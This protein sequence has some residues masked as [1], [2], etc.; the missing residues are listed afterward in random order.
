M[1]REKT[2]PHSNSLSALLNPYGTTQIGK[3]DTESCYKIHV[4]ELLELAEVMMDW[5]AG[6]SFAQIESSSA[7][8]VRLFPPTYKK[9]NKSKPINKTRI[10]SV[11]LGRKRFQ[12]SNKKV[13]FTTTRRIYSTVDYVRSYIVKPI[14]K[15]LTVK[16][17]LQPVLYV[18]LDTG[19]L[20]E[21][22]FQAYI[23]A[24][25]SNGFLAVPY[26]LSSYE[27]CVLVVLGESVSW[28]KAKRI[29]EQLASSSNTV[30][31]K[32]SSLFSSVP[33]PL[34]LNSHDELCSWIDKDLDQSEDIIKQIIGFN[35]AQ[36]SAL[37]DELNV[38]IVPNQTEE[39]N[40]EIAT[41]PILDEQPYFCPNDWIVERSLRLQLIEYLG[42]ED[43]NALKMLGL[44]LFGRKCQIYKDPV[45][46]ESHIAA[47]FNWEKKRRNN[48]AI[49]GPAL[50]F[51][52]K[53]VKVVY[54]PHSY[55]G[56]A[57]SFKLPDLPQSL[58][59]GS[60]KLGPYVDP[61]L[62]GTGGRTREFVTKRIGQKL[63]IAKSSTS[64]YP[65][66]T[67]DL[68][69]EH[70]NNLPN[71]YFQKITNQHME[72]MLSAVRN[73][74]GRGNYVALN[75]LRNIQLFPQPIY[76][77]S[78]KTCRIY[79]VGSS[80]QNLSRSIRNIAFRGN[81]KV[82]LRH[83]QLSIA[84]YLYGYH[85]LDHH[86]KNGTLWDYLVEETGLSKGKLKSILYSSF[87]MSAKE[88]YPSCNPALSLH[89]IEVDD[90]RNFGAVREMKQLLDHRTT[91]IY[92][93]LDFVQEDV[94]KNKFQ[95]IPFN[96]KLAAISQCLELEILSS[97]ISY[98]SGLKDN[99][100]SLFLHDGFF[101]KGDKTK[102]HG[103]AE[104]MKLL[105]DEKCRTLGIISGLDVVFS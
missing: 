82:D 64:N 24:V 26:R 25:V 68:L 57:T 42:V 32:R 88:F 45:A 53:H 5:L 50:E 73:L 30:L 17:F 46:D 3:G 35:K 51:I 8:P 23:D 97:S 100:I 41:I 65:N 76:K 10:T 4:P 94:F 91:F 34:S 44:Y 98:I 72:E 54:N 40:A 62:L 80:Y 22:E 29:A 37:E 48:K 7:N 18:N 2:L 1:G 59:T 27:N 84:C 28:N 102:F 15:E 83:S 13:K 92:S 67:S 33:A 93:K 47:L 101:I 77:K 60:K 61:V 74:A 49:V 43:K 21:H 36:P 20:L 66:Q 79:T 56:L 38:A 104:K 89:D 71:N 75:A 55:K 6:C 39:N 9:D 63:S 81:L 90:V 103:I 52:S 31:I 19:E 14:T 58:I 69:L 99:Q 11:L 96:E 105:V 86:L 85:G 95:D 78:T 87:F 70:L 12:V 16:W